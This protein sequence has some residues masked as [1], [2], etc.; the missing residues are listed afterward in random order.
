MSTNFFKSPKRGILLPSLAVNSSMQPT[1]PFPTERDYERRRKSNWFVWRKSAT[2]EKCFRTKSFSI[3]FQRSLLISH[4]M[5]IF[6]QYS[7]LISNTMSVC[8]QDSLLI[9]VTFGHRSKARFGIIFNPFKTYTLILLLEARQPNAFL[10]AACGSGKQQR[11]RVCQSD[12]H[13]CEE[14][15]LK[16]SVKFVHTCK[17]PNMASGVV[18]KNGGGLPHQK[19]KLCS[20]PADICQLKEQ[21]TLICVSQKIDNGR[22]LTFSCRER[23]SQL[24]FNTSWLCM[25]EIFLCSQAHATI[26]CLVRCMR[27][28]SGVAAWKHAG[29]AWANDFERAAKSINAILR[30]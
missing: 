20:S 22:L 3:C 5:G 11:N 13:S 16:V 26:T 21:Q 29:G 2:R 19:N 9:S 10:S 25:P 4:T 30:I 27:G 24:T 7:L 1:T 28:S 23:R 12:A 18:P 15:Q 14:S 8:F 17:R 6:F